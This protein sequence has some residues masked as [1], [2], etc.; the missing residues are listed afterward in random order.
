MKWK[1]TWMRVWRFTFCFTWI[2]LNK[3]HPKNKRDKKKR[4]MQ[5]KLSKW[6]TSLS[7]NFNIFFIF[8]KLDAFSK[9]Q[10]IIILIKKELSKKLTLLIA[11]FQHFQE[12]FII[13]RAPTKMKNWSNEDF[14]R[15]F[16]MI[17]EINVNLGQLSLVTNIFTSCNGLSKISN[18]FSIRQFS[19]Y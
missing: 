12:S 11:P 17:F 1:Y 15:D 8:P 18:T 13:I 2:I 14:Q 16:G 4:M 19:S 6:Q 10:F 9:M 5:K 3:K 7:K